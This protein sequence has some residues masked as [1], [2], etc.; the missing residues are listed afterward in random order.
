MSDNVIKPSFIKP[1]VKSVGPQPADILIVGEAPGKNEVSAGVPFVGNSGKELDR[2]LH[3][4]GI[5]RTD[6]RLTNVCPVQPPGNKIEKFYLKNTKAE[7]IPG[8]QIQQGIEALHAEILSTRPRI[9]LALGDTALWALTGERGIVKWRG[10]HLRYSHPEEDFSCDLLPTYHPAAILRQWSWRFIGVMDLKRAASWLS[11]PPKPPDVEFLLRPSFTAACEALL[12][13]PPGIIACDIETRGGHI[14]CIGFGWSST[15]AFCIP[16]M[17]VERDDGYWTE[18]EEIELISIMR[19]VFK[20]SDIKWVFQN[21]LYDLQYIARFWGVVPSVWMDTM[22]AHHVC[23]A[24][25]PKGLDFLS[26]MYREYHRYWKDDGKTWD[27]STG[28][29][30]LWEYNCDDCISTWEVAD[31]LNLQLDRMNL[32]KQFEF[33]MRQFNAVFYM[34]VRGVRCDLSHKNELIFQ[35]DAAKAELMTWILTAVGGNEWG[36]NEKM[37]GSY[38]QMQR[39]FYDELRV[40]PIRNRKT[41]SVTTDDK[42]LETIL[43]RQPVLRPLIKRIR[44]A[45]SVGVFLSTFARMPLDRDGRIRCS[46][47]IAG[48]ETYRYSSSQNAF[49][50]G[51]NLQNIPA[52][53][54]DSDESDY[55]L[56]N[57]KKIFQPDIG[58][59]LADAD[60]DRAD[61]QVVAAE[62]NDEIL[63]QM[64]REGADIHLE[65]AKDIFSNERLT[66][67][68]RE[69]QLAKA[70]VHATNYGATPPTLARALGITIREAE[71]FQRRWFAAHPGISDWHSRIEDSLFT[72]RKVANKFGFERYYFDRIE[73]VLP[74]ALAWIPQS[75]VALVISRGLVAIHENHPEIHCLLQ[76]HDS[77]VFQYPK[78]L[79]NPSLRKARAA[80]EVEI[81]YDDPLTIPVG[82]KISEVSYGDTKDYEPPELSIISNQN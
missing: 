24:G 30:Q 33:Q 29:D 5:L 43:K 32:R 16:L 70:G 17:C 49:G 3:E 76:V 14:A 40:K 56:P 73:G 51:T 36:Y 60:L 54:E 2:M 28:E 37:L 4:A 10:S 23:F 64:F 62:A 82:F 6:C 8:P 19:Q 63:R 18:G 59:E 45:R 39:L 34:M 31:Q 22:L 61:A 77:L 53:D 81:P 68:S 38:K 48:T 35:L 52:G 67:D 20:R 74:E 47:N 11:E 58:C 13:L 79:R 1:Q 25:L 44:A 41:G 80:M 72:T 46:Y 66:K 9:I 75:T 57:I 69:R 78:H 71:R 7:R 55:P 12:N 42:A 65:N 21:G 50:S 26:S 27:K 15:Q